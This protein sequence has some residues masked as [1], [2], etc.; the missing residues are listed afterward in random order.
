[1]CR[2]KLVPGWGTDNAF[3]FGVTDTTPFNEVQILE[4]TDFA[5]GML[6]DN[7]VA[8]RVPEPGSFV[9]MMLGGAFALCPRAGVPP[10]L[11]LRDQRRQLLVTG[12]PRFFK[13]GPP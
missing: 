7:V 5:D 3:F 11:N 13:P 12:W 8:G 2:S 4:S 6:Y 9:L 10:W 1:M